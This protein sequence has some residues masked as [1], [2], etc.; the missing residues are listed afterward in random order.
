MVKIASVIGRSFFDRVV[1]DVADRIDDVDRRLEHL[2]DV[3]LIRSRMR[4]GE[5]EYLFKH[6]LAQRGRI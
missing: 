6:A 2:K 1:K 4:M 5:L 3:Q